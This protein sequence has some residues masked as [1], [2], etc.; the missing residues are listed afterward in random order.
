M[1]PE[2]QHHIKTSQELKEL[3]IFH[4]TLKP[5]NEELPQIIQ[6][7]RTEDE[8]S[9]AT[10]KSAKLQREICK[11]KAELEA[12]KQNHIKTLQELKELKSRHGKGNETKE[13]EITTGGLPKKETTTESL[14]ELKSPHRTLITE[15]QELAEIIQRQRGE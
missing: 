1:E 6:K 4:E 12:E 5:I 14:K 9:H 3:K 13:L 11:F 7:K 15:N 2:K 10:D 8:L